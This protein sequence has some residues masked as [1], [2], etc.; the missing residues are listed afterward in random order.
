M[1]LTF[2]SLAM[3]LIT[4]LP[5]LWNPFGSYGLKELLIDHLFMVCQGGE[6]FQ[7]LQLRVSF[8]YPVHDEENL[9]RLI[10]RHLL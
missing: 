10:L 9:V 7:R 6:R 8:V 4:N 2:M 3:Q 5:P 1:A